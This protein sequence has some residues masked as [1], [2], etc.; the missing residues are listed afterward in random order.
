M[1]L[2]PPDRSSPSPVDDHVAGVRGGRSAGRGSGVIPVVWVASRRKK[3]PKRQGLPRNNASRNQVSGAAPSF[4]PEG[5]SSQ[6]DGRADGEAELPELRRA[7]GGRGSRVVPGAR[8]RISA[9]QAAPGAL[10]AP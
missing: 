7:P 1:E 3:Q 9:R 5:R 6:A 8:H 10:P 2:Q 4:Y